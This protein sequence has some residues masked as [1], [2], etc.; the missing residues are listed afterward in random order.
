V[1]EVTAK[2]G[3]WAKLDGFSS[4]FIVRVERFASER[5]V[6]PPCEDAGRFKNQASQAL[7]W[8]SVTDEVIAGAMA[9]AE[10]LSKSRQF[11]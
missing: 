1:A 9:S 2:A 5:R 8:D 6:F 10:F 7:R 11:R 4:R 3:S